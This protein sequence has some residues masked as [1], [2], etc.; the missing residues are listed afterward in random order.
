[1]D[2]ITVL[3]L[4]ACCEDSWRKCM[5]SALHSTSPLE[6]TWYMLM[7]LLLLGFLLL[8]S[9]WKEYHIYD[10]LIR[11]TDS[12]YR[13]RYRIQL[14][15]TAAIWKISCPNTQHH[16]FQLDH[17]PSPQG[18][19][20]HDQRIQRNVVGMMW[21]PPLQSLSLDKVQTPSRGPWVIRL[22]AHTLSLSQG[23][24]FSCAVSSFQFRGSSRF[25]PSSIAESWKY[26]T[27]LTH[28]HLPCFS[29]IPSLDL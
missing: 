19:C 21:P 18:W 4:S 1:M 6:N 20:Q 9:S 24:F 14:V 11:L 13:Q 16:D 27:W 29:W 17:N 2:I 23:C 12:Y 5:W 10:Y 25:F 8:C 7:L 3:Y 15:W 26:L 22:R 28:T